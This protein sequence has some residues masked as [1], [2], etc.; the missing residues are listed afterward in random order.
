MG[1]Y[2]KY[3]ELLSRPIEGSSNNISHI[4][5]DDDVGLDN[6]FS[7]PDRRPLLL[8]IFIFVMH[9]QCV[10]QFFTHE[11]CMD[12]LTNY[13]CRSLFYLNWRTSLILLLVRRF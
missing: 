8:Q 3:V 5:I 10:S 7:I 1:Y 6:M 9:V 11:T 12:I 4:F 2:L 13:Q